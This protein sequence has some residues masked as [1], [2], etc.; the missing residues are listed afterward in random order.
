MVEP[1]QIE[2]YDTKHIEVISNQRDLIETLFTRFDQLADKIQKVYEERDRLDPDAEA[3]N[4]DSTDF[5]LAYND[6][7]SILEESNAQLTLDLVKLTSLDKKYQIM[8]NEQLQK[9]QK[10]NHGSLE[11][12]S[13]NFGSLSKLEDTKKKLDVAESSVDEVT[14]IGLTEN[15]KPLELKELSKDQFLNLLNTEKNKRTKLNFTNEKILGPK[16]RAIEH[17]VQSYRAM[18]QKWDKVLSFDIKELDRSMVNFKKKEG[19]SLE[20]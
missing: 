3:D 1:L 10:I 15:G 13:K 18:Q 11:I 19:I 8:I 20:K 16:L 4:I 14:K 17:Q 7:A 12:K 9:L 5:E 2:T 6:L